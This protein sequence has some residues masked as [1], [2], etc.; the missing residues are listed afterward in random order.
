ESTP[1]SFN[2]LQR[3][4]K[5]RSVSPFELSAG[6][7]AAGFQASLLKAH[8]KKLKQRERKSRGLKLSKTKQSYI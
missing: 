8:C 4:Q 3:A 6:R 5:Y 2:L 7:E 1:R